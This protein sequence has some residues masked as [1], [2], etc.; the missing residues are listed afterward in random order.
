[1]SERGYNRIVVMWAL[2]LGRSLASYV[3]L[4]NLLKLSGVDSPMAFFMEI[5]KK[6]PKIQ[7]ESQKFPNSQSSLKNEQSW[8]YHTS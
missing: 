1:M 2:D 7:I 6:N 8:R 3:V 4:L 5:E